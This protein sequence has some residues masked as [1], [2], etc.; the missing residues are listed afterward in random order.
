MLADFWVS[1][2]GCHP[3]GRSDGV[4]WTFDAGPRSTPMLAGALDNLPLHFD[5]DR[6]ELADFEHTVRHLQGGMGLI[7]GPIPAELGPKIGA[8]EGWDA[9]A[10]YLREGVDAPAAP[11]ATGDIAA[12]RAVFKTLGCHTCHGG[13]H[14]A[15]TKD[16]PDKRAEPLQHDPPSLWGVAQTAPYLHDGAARTLDDVLSEERHLYAGVSRPIAVDARERA[17]LIAFVRSIDGATEPIQ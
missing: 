5:G 8:D 17:A 1:C 15:P 13:G 16:T 11:T 7:R 10:A 12:G 6:D 14:F 9:I 2:G 3:D 4:T